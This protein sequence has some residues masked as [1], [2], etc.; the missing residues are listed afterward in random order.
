MTW[1]VSFISLS[2]FSFTRK[3]RRS[4]TR[5]ALYHKDG[6]HHEHLD[7]PE[8]KYRK[9]ILGKSGTQ[10]LPGQGQVRGSTGMTP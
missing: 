7:V 6:H 9:V 5:T 3:G 8:P 1:Y 2:Y 10:N 4:K